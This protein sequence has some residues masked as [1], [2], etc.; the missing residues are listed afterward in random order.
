M[1]ALTADML[2][3]IYEG[4]TAL[5]K[6]KYVV[7]FATLRKPFRETLFYLSLLLADEDEF[8]RLFENGPSDGMKLRE[9]RPA[10][11]EGIFQAALTTMLVDEVFDAKHLNRIAFDKSDPD[12]LAGL[13]DK[14]QHLVTSFNLN[15]RT[16]PLNFNFVFKDSRDADVF[17]A[18]YPHIAYVLMYLFGVVT[19]L[20]SRALP[21]D[22]DHVGKLVLIMF[23]VYHSLFC[24]GRS[25]I[26]A[27]VNRAFKDIMK[28]TV[29]DAEFTIDKAGA[30]RFFIAERM[31]CKRCGADTDFPILWLMAKA[32]IT[33]SK[34]DPHPAQ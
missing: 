3:F 2:N 23:A 28:C 18:S 32:G 19:S 21:I 26:V 7:G 33:L 4:L 6:R 22:K 14:A 11:R 13:F 27:T 12:G 1:L 8:F 20:F 31:V 29:C 16:E 9:F 10:Q 5:G 30:P 24:R 17:Q 15:L 34:D 25:P